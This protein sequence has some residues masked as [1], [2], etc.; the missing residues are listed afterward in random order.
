METNLRLRLAKPE[1]KIEIWQIL[2][3]A[4][5]RRK[6]DGSQQWQN[7]YPNLGTVEN[8]TEKEIGFVFENK[9]ETIGYVAIIFND[10]PAYENIVGNWISDIE[11]LAIHRFAISENWVGKGLSKIMF[12]LI[13]EYAL[14]KNIYS[15][16][17]DTNFDNVQMLRLMDKLN[18]TYCGEVH[19]E[20]KS[21]KAFEKI[22]R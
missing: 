15:I 1:D 3:Q 17:L 13:E 9:S 4:I 11:F 2:Q 6:N 5:E 20:G 14:S 19:Y 16:R 8:D 10:E 7:G 22:L 21:R 12:E 18:Y